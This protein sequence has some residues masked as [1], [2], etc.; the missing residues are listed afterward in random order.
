[1]FNH[2]DVEDHDRHYDHIDHHL[3]RDAVVYDDGLGGG[4]GGGDGTG[5]TGGG[6]G[7]RGGGDADD[8]H[9]QHH[10]SLT[11]PLTSYKYSTLHLLCHHA[12]RPHTRTHP[13][14]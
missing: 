9:H 14:V 3:D 11:H 12:P 4:G 8:D 6:G 5:G 1:M 10:H 7:G 2:V 13:L